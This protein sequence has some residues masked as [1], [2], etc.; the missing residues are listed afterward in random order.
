MLQRQFLI[1]IKHVSLWQ[2]HHQEACCIFFKLYFVSH[3]L[4]DHV[5]YMISIKHHL[6][7]TKITYDGKICFGL[8]GLLA[9][10]LFA[11]NIFQK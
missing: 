11:K 8:C 10:L 6:L 5:S 2:Y 3:G 9:Q 1:K 4:S 7:S